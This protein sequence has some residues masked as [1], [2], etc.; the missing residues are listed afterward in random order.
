[1][2]EHFYAVASGVVL[3]ASQ[4]G[5]IGAIGGTRGIC[6]DRSTPPPTAWLIPGEARRPCFASYCDSGAGASASLGPV[7]MGGVAEASAGGG[8]GRLGLAGDN[9]ASINPT[10]PP[11]VA[12]R[13][14]AE[15]WA[16]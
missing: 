9:S 3:P 13:R 2:P 10:S 1:M 12:A 16:K 14:A 5:D 4:F 15:P 11:S 7:G 6:L 8:I